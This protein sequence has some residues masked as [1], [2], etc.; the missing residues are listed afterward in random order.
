[1]IEREILEFQKTGRASSIVPIDVDG[2]LRSARWF[3]LIDG[4]AAELEQSANDPDDAN[5]SDAV[6]SRIEKSFRYTR[7]KERLRRATIGAAV[8]MVALLAVGTGGGGCAL[9]PGA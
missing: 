4:I 8:L 2:S 5:P 1:A 3:S 9:R 6:F 7:G